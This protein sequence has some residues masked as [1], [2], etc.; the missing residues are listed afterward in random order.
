VPHYDAK[1]PQVKP[2][3]F[4]PSD[5]YLYGMYYA[6]QVQATHD[7]AV[8]ICAPWGQEYIR[9][10]RALHQLGLRLPTSGIPVLRFDYYGTGDSAGEDADFNIER[11]LQD[12][13]LA[14]EQVRQDSGKSNIVLV[15]WRLGAALAALASSRLQLANRLVLWDPIVNGST[16]MAELTE[17]HRHNLHYYLSNIENNARTQSLEILGFA[18]SAA[19]H[20]QIQLIDLL[21]MPYAAQMDMLLI[22]REAQAATAQLRQA[23]THQPVQLR[24][25]LIDGPL[26]WTENTDKG[27]VPHQTLQTIVS[28]IIEG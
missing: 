20:S 1:Q 2:F 9:T 22:E 11:S 15:G 6:P 18:V 8:V 3:F 24:Y 7:T 26:L 5:E 28:W 25:E 16:Y 14:V 23:L 27:L 12:I 21:G 10:H 4:G 19:M 13:S 17:W